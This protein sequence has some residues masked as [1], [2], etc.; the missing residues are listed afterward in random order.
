METSMLSRR[1]LLASQ[2][3]GL[4]LGLADGWLRPV[5]AQTLGPLAPWTVAPHADPRI[6]AAA[7]AVL[8]PNPH[9]RQPWQLRLIGQ[10]SL[11]LHCDLDRRLPVTDPL[12]RQI[13]IGLGCFAEL[14]RLAAAAQGFTAEITPFPEG[15]PQ[16]RL[17]GRPARRTPCPAG[18]A[19]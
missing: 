10:D 17:D 7:W 8:S 19:R 11:T 4:S 2:A 13:T 18:R 16:P 15:E 9:N 1:T 12:D 5:R 14:F 3:A 6:A